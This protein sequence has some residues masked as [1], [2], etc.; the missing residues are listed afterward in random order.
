MSAPVTTNQPL[1]IGASRPA[2][3]APIEEFHGLID[4]VLIYRRILATNEI[5]TLASILSRS[6]AGW[7]DRGGGLVEY[8]AGTLAAGASTT[9]VLRANAASAGTYTNLAFA[10]GLQF[11][12]NSANNLDLE[13][14]TVTLEANLG[15]TKSDAPD[16]VFA[17]GTLTYTVVVTNGG[18]T[19]ASSVVVTDALP[20]GV[21]FNAGASTAGSLF[22]NGLVI[23]N[24]GTLPANTSS[25][26]IPSH[27]AAFTYQPIANRR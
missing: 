18:P 13:T 23:Y 12:T 24:L 20:Q 26:L 16:P 22:T 2:A 10:S 11:D 3:G 6:D 25:S 15:I 9:L 1:W 7:M 19:F 5:L 27:A 21:T 8:N 14:S 17:G 4:D